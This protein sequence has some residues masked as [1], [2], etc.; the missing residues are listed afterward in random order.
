[1]A[2]GLYARSWN[3]PAAAAAAAGAA[4]TRR[5][6]SA[7]SDSAVLAVAL[8]D[9]SA[10]TCVAP[11]KLLFVANTERGRMKPCRRLSAKAVLASL[12]IFCV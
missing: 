9:R 6:S 5:A 7:A 10:V 11:P 8:L 2:L 3:A 4:K 12:S 1:M